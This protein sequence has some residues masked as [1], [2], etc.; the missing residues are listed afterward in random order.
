MRCSLVTAAALVLA[1]AAGAHAGAWTRGPR[2]FYAKLALS[3]LRTSS[4]YT[5][6]GHRISTAKF[7]SSS[8]DLYAEYGLGRRLTG[9]VQFPIVKSASFETT[10]TETGV[11]DLG[12]ELKYG[13]RLGASPFALGVGVELP[14]GDER[15]AAALEDQAGSPGGFIRLPTGDGEFNTRVTLYVSRS[16]HSMPAYISAEA[17]Y[18]LRNER[19]TD[20][21]MFGLQAGYG[22]AG[23]LWLNANLRGVGPVTNPDPARALETANGFGEGVQYIGIGIGAAC[24]VVP[25]LGLT[26]DVYRATGRITNIHSGARLVFGLAAEY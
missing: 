15:G 25:H 4:F 17:G 18:N 3:T 19:F 1:G 20:E 24:D 21:Y 10:E 13:L 11:G 5:P 23:R 16:F 2:S 14:T 26:F 6:D 9:V 22:V 12:L 8:L 7:S